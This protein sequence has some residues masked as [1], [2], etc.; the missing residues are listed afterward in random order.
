MAPTLGH[1]GP[2]APVPRRATAADAE[3]LA[4]LIS[5]IAADHPIELELTAREVV[6]RLEQDPGMVIDGAWDGDEL[7]AFTGVVPS[8]ASAGPIRSFSWATSIRRAWGR[9]S[10]R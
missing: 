7:V 3:P 9:V 8:A 5:R 4:A 6:D 1:P 10:R 2:G